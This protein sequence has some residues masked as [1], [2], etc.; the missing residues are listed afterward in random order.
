MLASRGNGC[1][2]KRGRDE[3][4]EEYVE[5]SIA[6]VKAAS[7]VKGRGKAVKN[8]K[9]STLNGNNADAK[10]PPKHAKTE[11]AKISSARNC[12]LQCITGSHL[13]LQ[14]ADTTKVRFTTVAE[15]E[16][17]GASASK[18]VHDEAFHTRK[19]IENAPVFR[20]DFDLDVLKQQPKNRTAERDQ[21]QATVDAMKEYA[22]RTCR[23]EEGE[24][25]DEDEEPHVPAKPLKCKHQRKADAARKVLTMEEFL[26][27]RAE[28][29]LAK[30]K[31]AISKQAHQGTQD[32]AADCQPHLKERD[33][34]HTIL[35]DSETSAVDPCLVELPASTIAPRERATKGTR[36][37]THLCSSERK[38]VLAFEETP[39][40]SVH[41]RCGVYHLVQS[42]PAQGTSDEIGPSADMAAGTAAQ[43]K[44]VIHY[45]KVTYPFTLVVSE[46]FHGVFLDYHARHLKAFNA[47][48]YL[49]NDDP[50][51]FIGHAIMWK[52]QVWAHLDSL[53]GGPVATTPE[54][55]FQ[56]GGLVFPDFA[57]FGKVLKFQYAPGN[58]CLC[59][60]GALY[61]GM[62][63][64]EPLPVDEKDIVI[65]TAVLGF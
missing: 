34:Q 50:G 6:G 7:V 28:F 4:D 57:Q 24:S 49:Q 46:Q 9:Q 44:A 45:F 18:L 27:K 59:F 30:A 19:F 8:A 35:D 42:W 47:G 58:L 25:K 10:L 38:K 12:Q 61:H 39:D 55:A 53:E 29:F 2:A 21:M 62:E 32:F 65:G 60:A 23:D 56:R 15:Y 37:D 43:S 3:S 40:E 5:S 54:G 31:H 1:S 63:E 51:L 52:L 41:E 26:A 13:C 16:P 64:W 14:L 17:V 20:C 11:G 33:V 36:I 22:G 48:C